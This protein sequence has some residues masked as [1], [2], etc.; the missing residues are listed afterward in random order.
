MN[1]S[2]NGC[3]RILWSIVQNCSRSVIHFWRWK[4]L[5][6]FMFCQDF[7]NT[8]NSSTCKLQ[9]ILFTSQIKQKFVPDTLATNLTHCVW[10]ATGWLALKF[11][12]M[13]IIDCFSETDKCRLVR[14]F[15]TKPGGSRSA[16][17]YCSTPKS[18]FMCY[19]AFT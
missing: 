14:F 19:R 1:F 3:F 17:P 16:C 11:S 2:T 15:G 13:V 12:Y 4:N 7:I 6:L 5:F 8:A 18:F 9:A 10:L